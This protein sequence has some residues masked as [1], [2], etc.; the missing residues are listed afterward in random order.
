VRT[1]NEFLPRFQGVDGK[2]CFNDQLAPPEIVSYAT[3]ITQHVCGGTRQS[4]WEMGKASRLIS[5]SVRGVH[6]AEVGHTVVT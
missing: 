3:G 5:S 4:R 6:C 1:K 2:R